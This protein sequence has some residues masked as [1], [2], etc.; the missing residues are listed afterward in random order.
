M[1][2]SMRSH[3]KAI[4]GVLAIALVAACNESTPPN[5]DASGT[6]V[7]T[8]INGGSLPFLLDATATDTLVIKSGSIVINTDGTFVETLSADE[9]KSGTT[10]TQTNVCPGI[11]TQ[12]GNALT[13]SE[14]PNSDATCGGTYGASWNGSD[15]VS[16]LF[17]GF[18]LEYTKQTIG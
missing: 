17:T 14:T 16:L 2:F 3:V 7:L 12:R 15:T 9:T 11:Y 4:F 8:A 13:F 1:R 5:G 6:Y 18:T 10:T